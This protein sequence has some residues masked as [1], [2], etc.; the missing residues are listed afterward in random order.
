[1]AILTHYYK[2]RVAQQT[3]TSTTLVELTAYTIAWSDLTTAGFAA[4]DDVFIQVAVKVGGSGAG[5]SY[6]FIVGFGTTYAGRTDDDTS[7]NMSEPSVT[8]LAGHQYTWIDK[9]TLVTNENIYFSAMIES[10]NTASYDEFSVLILKLTG[11]NTND[12]GYAEATHTTAP[13]AY[14]TTGA[15]FTTGAAGDWF[16]VANGKWIINNTS[17]DMFTAISA[18]GVDY[19][20]HILEGESNNDEYNVGTFA[21]R[22]G[23]GSGQTVQTRYH[24]DA[25]T[26]V[27]A[28]TRSAIFG[29]RLDIF[30]NHAG[31]HTTNTTSF[32][33]V[34][35]TYTE[36]AGFPAFSL[37][38]T[39][40]VFSLCWPLFNPVGITDR[41][42]GRI[43]LANSD[44]PAANSNRFGACDNGSTTMR[45][46]PLLDGYASSQSS[47]T[48]DFDY[49][50]AEDTTAG[51]RNC[52]E[53]VA[54]IFSLELAGAPGVSSFLPFWHLHKVNLYQ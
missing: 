30:E 20:E 47:G 19:S 52:V 42:Y 40:P 24:R 50:I 18:G 31:A 16:I 12:W 26:T 41:V 45:Y 23:L 3:T 38:T 14:D 15:S 32:G 13:A 46:A 39:G 1:M 25:V 6:R 37:T 36:M 17:G 34:I 5:T 44:W 2:P 29:L 22:A 8:T 9:R 11:L 21:Y 43:Q 53:Q 48:L 10:A 49:D 54:A 51:A 27:H 28:F 35:D 33:T 7:N 4:G